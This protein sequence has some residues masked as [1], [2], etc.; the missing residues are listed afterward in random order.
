MNI[1][2]VLE[3]ISS[4]RTKLLE[5]IESMP[6][7]Q[8]GVNHIS[9]NP[10]IAI[11]SFSHIN[12]NYCTL[13]PRYYLNCKAKKA[14]KDMIKFTKIEN[15]AERIDKIIQSGSIKMSSSLCDTIKLNPEFISFLKD[16]W[17]KALKEC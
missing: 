2:A 3:Q 6:D 4:F 14:L 7:A 9:S 17:E 16:M 15:L 11:V 5:M 8:T 13:S 10:T 12:K 1:K